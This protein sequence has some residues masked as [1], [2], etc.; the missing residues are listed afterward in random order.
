MGRHSPVLSAD[1]AQDDLQRG[2]GPDDW[3]AGSQYSALIPPVESSCTFLNTCT[4]ASLQT[5]S[6]TIWTPR[7]TDKKERN[8][9]GTSEE[10]NRWTICSYW[11]AND[12]VVPVLVPT[13]NPTHQLTSHHVHSAPECRTRGQDDHF[14]KAHCWFIVKEKLGFAELLIVLSEQKTR[15]ETVDCGAAS[16]LWNMQRTT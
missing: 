6:V 16:Q 13:S 4:A 14:L 12:S 9:G 8:G 15:T 5:G 7:K 2:K 11:S 3:S 1:P 10:T